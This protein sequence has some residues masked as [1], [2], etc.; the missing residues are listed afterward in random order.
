V[1]AFDN[2]IVVTE[3]ASIQHN[4]RIMKLSI[5]EICACSNST[6]IQWT[7]VG[8]Q[9]EWLARGSR[10]V[11]C[12]G[13]PHGIQATLELAYGVFTLSTVGVQAAGCSCS[14]WTR[15]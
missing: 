15:T 9:N 14:V 13:T 2:I 7:S 4:L 12:S 6:V 3:F 11:T 5:L 8:K 10:Q 1:V